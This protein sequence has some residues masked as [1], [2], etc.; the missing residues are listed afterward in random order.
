MR[1]FFQ[2]LGI[3]SFFGLWSFL[4]DWEIALLFFLALL[5]HEL[6][7]KTVFYLAGLK[8]HLVF[9][10]V[11]F[12]CVAEEVGPYNQIF[13]DLGAGALYLSGCFVS[14]C[15][16]VVCRLLAVF[17]NGWFLSESQWFVLWWAPLVLNLL[18]LL[19]LLPITDSGQTLLLISNHRRINPYYVASFGVVQGAVCLGF[20]SK[21]SLALLV[22]LALLKLPFAVEIERTRKDEVD[23]RSRVLILAAWL[24]L[25]SASGA[26][27]MTDE[28]MRH[29]V[30]GW[31][32]EFFE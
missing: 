8:S 23:F 29:M 1:F 6:G 22:T 27:I 5:I 15:Y 4:A 7:H 12:L 25:V 26:L 11:A 31:F 30:F 2:I 21:I 19:I 10:P 13:S 32:G 9:T 17:C 24:F 20:M 3:G 28:F 18:N 14:L 16:A